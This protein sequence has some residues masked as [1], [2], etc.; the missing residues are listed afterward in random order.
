MRDPTYKSYVNQVLPYVNP[1]LD[2]VSYSNWEI[3]EAQERV[4]LVGCIG[5][6]CRGERSGSPAADC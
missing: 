2:Y 1:P 4:S 3:E 6:L 5:C